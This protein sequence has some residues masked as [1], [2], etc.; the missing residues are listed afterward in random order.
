MVTG[1]VRRSF[2]RMRTRSGRKG[3]TGRVRL[4]KWRVPNRLQ[5]SPGSILS[6]VLLGHLEGCSSTAGVIP[7]QGGGGFNTECADAITFGIDLV[8]NDGLATRVGGRLRT[9][10]AACG[11]CDQYCDGGVC[12]GSG[13][14]ADDHG[15]SDHV[16]MDVAGGVS[17]YRDRQC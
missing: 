11:R 14:A 5:D 10:G 17:G 3:E 6:L 8:L 9:D 7:S 4:L 13:A 1:K 2:S 16:P 15:H 12:N